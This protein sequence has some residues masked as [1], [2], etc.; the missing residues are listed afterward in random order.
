MHCEETGWR[1]DGR[2]DTLG[3]RTMPLPR[4]R[5]DREHTLRLAIAALARMT[6]TGAVAQTAAPLFA[7][8]KVE[9][10]ENV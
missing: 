7:T 9:G 5:L 8:T 1:E 6:A 3:C 4:S 10:T 2:G